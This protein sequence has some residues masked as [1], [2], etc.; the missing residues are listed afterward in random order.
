MIDHCID[1]IYYIRGCTKSGIETK[2]HPSSL[3]CNHFERR[4]VYKVEDLPENQTLISKYDTIRIVQQH[5]NYLRDANVTFS[6]NALIKL[7]DAILS[8]IGDL[9]CFCQDDLKSN[10][11][12]EESAEWIQSN[13]SE[14]ML[15]MCS[16]CGFDTGCLS[17]KF[18]PN[19]GIRMRNAL[20]YRG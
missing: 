19:C 8:C 18:C 4:T 13:V 5:I 6:E 14:S 9:P 10:T 20:G 3:P 16:K 15:S 7:S 17:F 12:E 2:I 1:C 11:A